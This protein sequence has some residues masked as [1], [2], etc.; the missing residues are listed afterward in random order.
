MVS[1]GEVGF[2]LVTQ[3]LLGGNCRHLC[4]TPPAC[5]SAIFSVPLALVD[6]YVDSLALCHSWNGQSAKSHGLA[7]ALKSIFKTTLECNCVLR[8]FYVPS[9]SN[10]ADKP[11]P[12]LTMSDSS[13][14][15]RCWDKIQDAFGG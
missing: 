13:L 4:I 9:S 11:S 2:S 7:E 3:S 10:L 5:L 15:K 6:V 12:S 8:L 14:S 1:N